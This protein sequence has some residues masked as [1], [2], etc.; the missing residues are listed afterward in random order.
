MHFQWQG[1]RPAVSTTVSFSQSELEKQVVE[2]PGDRGEGVCAEMR[3]PQA[4]A[5]LPPL[6][7]GLATAERGSPRIRWMSQCP[8]GPFHLEVLYDE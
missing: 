5:P 2:A 7:A 4:R 6:L 1:E 8:V 3:V